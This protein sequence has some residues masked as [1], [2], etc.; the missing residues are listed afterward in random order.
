MKRILFVDDEPHIL[1]GLRNLLRKQAKQWEMVFAQGGAAALEEFKKEPFDVV[2]SD[3]RMPGIDGAALLAKVKE[4][5]PASARI[6]LSGHA[7]RESVV[8]ALPVAHQFLSKPCD[9]TLLR[10][11]IDRACQLQKLLHNASIRSVVGSL[12]KLPS[13]PQVYWQLTDAAS[14]PEATLDDFS[15]IVEQDPAMT[16]KVL[17]LVNSSYFGL[18][19]KLASV[20]QAV[21]YL[22]INLLRSLALSAHAFGEMGENSSHLISLEKL[23]RHAL[24]TARLAKRMVRDPHQAGEAFTAALVHDVGRIVLAMGVPDII[25]ETLRRSVAE[26]RR[27][28]DIE[29]EL[30]G[31]CHAEVGA[32]LLGVWGLPLT[33]VEAVA[34]HHEPSQ[35]AAGASLSLA[36]VHVADALLGDES[37][38][39][40]DGDSPLALDMEFFERS[41]FARRLDEFRAFVGDFDQRSD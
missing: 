36:A 12:E 2:V 4:L 34:Y 20:R 38:A 26:N 39:R 15:E 10:E 17:Q 1:D 6:I 25:E 27:I 35:A 9:A 29:R 30:L 19:Q 31:V 32:Y 3:M 23:Q 8:R 18:P 14:R 5:Y 16:A 40:K 13:T 37:G 41:P 24:Q 28:A 11:V 33:I 21:G 7:E 22:G